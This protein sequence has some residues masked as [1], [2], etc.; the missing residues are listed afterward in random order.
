HLGHLIHCLTFRSSQSQIH[1][2]S[3]SP[4]CGC[5]S[6]WLT[7]AGFAS[8]GV[9]RYNVSVGETERVGF[10]A[11][12]TDGAVYNNLFLVSDD[13]DASFF[14]LGD[15]GS[16]VLFANNLVV[17]LREGGASTPAVNAPNLLSWRNNAFYSVAGGAG[18]WP[19]SAEGGNIYEATSTL[20]RGV[21]A[22]LQ[23]LADLDLDAMSGELDLSGL[24]RTWPALEGAGTPVADE[25]TV[26]LY[27]NAVP[28]YC[29]PDIGIFQDQIDCAPASALAAG[30]S[31][32]YAVPATSTI[33]VDARVDAGATL[34]ATHTQG[35]TQTAVATTAGDRVTTTV[36]T[37]ATDSTITLACESGACDDIRFAT[38]DDEIVDGSFE[39][40][41]SSY[42]DKRSSPW[43]LWNA[44]GR[45]PRSHRAPRR[46]RSRAMRT[47]RRRSCRA[48]RSTRAARTASPAGSARTR[49]ARRRA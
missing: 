23:K 35:L 31:R 13:S 19:G 30:E 2:F 12:A 26:D 37:T 39:S 48:S 18:G 11:G 44:N 7:N 1:R 17:S 16:S 34:T 10:L 42:G 43:S 15:T 38:V 14:S 21:R 36:R 27:G 33:R 22:E 29:A 24:D 20:P 46:C 40:L 5:A 32:T 6:S 4:Y 9:Y 49:L 41:L 45:A 25:G 3:D 28:S 8:E 47:A